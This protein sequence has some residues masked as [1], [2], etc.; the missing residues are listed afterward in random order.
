[1]AADTL[2]ILSCLSEPVRER[3]PQQGSGAVL[4]IRALPSLPALLPVLVILPNGRDLIFPFFFSLFNPLLNPCPPPASLGTSFHP[5]PVPAVLIP[6]GIRW[7]FPLAHCF[8]GPFRGVSR[9]TS[10]LT[11]SPITGG[12]TASIPWEDV[13]R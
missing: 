9:G 8:G 3:N 1:M 7:V 2:S 10:L 13:R 4:T 5:Q 11:P 12:F 6:R